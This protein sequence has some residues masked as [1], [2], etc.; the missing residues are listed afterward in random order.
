MQG[1]SIPS[2]N[3][4]KSDENMT[5]F[6]FFF[7]YNINFVLA[8]LSNVFGLNFKVDLPGPCTSNWQKGV[9]L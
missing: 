6:F 8:W 5:K 3:D 1:T 2:K 4:G 7:S 9:N